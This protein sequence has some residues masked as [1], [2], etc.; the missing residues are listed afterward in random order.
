MVSIAICAVTAGVFYTYS[1]L[2]PKTLDAL[3]EKGKMENTIWVVQNFVPMLTIGIIITALGII[4]RCIKLPNS[5]KQ[6][7]KGIIM[8]ITMLFTYGVILPYVMSRSIGC[9]DPVPEGVEDVKS[10]L[11]NTAS[12]FVIQIIPFMIVT[13][14][15]FV[16]ASR[17]IE[18]LD[19]ETCENAG[20]VRADGGED[21]TAEAEIHQTEQEEIK[22]NEE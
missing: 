19:A 13:S 20:E 15:H 17:P 7:E 2:I 8:L 11:E 1:E 4:Y 9:F 22:E 14:Y 5:K 10:L 6:S 12:W 16:R 3:T 21:C 18:E